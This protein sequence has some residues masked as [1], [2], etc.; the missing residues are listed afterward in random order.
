MGRLAELL[1]DNIVR[2]YGIIPRNVIFF[3]PVDGYA[4]G[5]GSEDRPVTTF[6][7]AYAKCS[8]NKNDCIVWIGKTSSSKS[9]NSATVTLSKDGV[10]ILGFTP[11]VIEG[12]RCRFT[13]LSTATGVSPMVNITASNCIIANIRFNQGVDD[14][15]S[16]INVQITGERNHFINCEFAGI[17]HATQSAAGSCSLKLNG[18]SE[19]LFTDCVIGLDTIARDADASELIFDTAASRNTFKNCIFKSYISAAGF[20]TVTVADATGIDR[21]QI[22]DKCIFLTDSENQGTEQTEVFSVPA[23]VQGKIVLKDCSYLSD[24]ETDVWE[25]NARGIVWNNTPAAAAAGVGG[26][27][28]IID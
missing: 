24:G 8:A 5:D 13:Q 6:T 17:G 9:E 12:K 3:D 10:H 4:T 1:K 27:M 21:A 20:A 23:M 15:T 28:T 18:G 16:L 19:N 2:H 22:F 25:A 26:L 11:D 7:S 14:A